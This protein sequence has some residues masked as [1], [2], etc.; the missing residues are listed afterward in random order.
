M[1]KFNV[2]GTMCSEQTSPSIEREVGHFSTVLRVSFFPIPC[3][4]D[5][6]LDAFVSDVVFER[7]QHQI[8]ALEQLIGGSSSDSSNT[9]TRKLCTKFESW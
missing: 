3:P 1:F 9:R 2:L 6:L 8:V 5:V 4:K 7:L